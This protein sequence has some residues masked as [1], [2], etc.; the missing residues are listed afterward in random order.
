M[1]RDSQNDSTDTLESLKANSNISIAHL[2][3]NLYRYKFTELKNII[4]NYFDII[5]IAETKLDYSFS[6][7]QF[8]RD[9]S[10][11]SFHNGGGLL[12]Y[13]NENIPSK[14][15]NIT[16]PNDIEL[17]AL[18][19]STKNTKWILLAV[20]SLLILKTKFIF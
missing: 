3:I 1:H 14:P 11:D 5:V 16:L 20:Y 15:I 6:T 10:E 2:N 13:V 19:I 18:E 8:G 12:V 7:E 4:K 17:I 9:H